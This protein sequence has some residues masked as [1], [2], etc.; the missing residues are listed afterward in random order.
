MI[1]IISKERYD[2][3]ID[4]IKMYEESDKKL[5]DEVIHAK[6]QLKETIDLLSAKIEKEAALI[7]EK[8][9]LKSKITK[10]ENQIKKMQEEEKKH[11][12]IVKD[13]LKEAHEV[14]KKRVAK[15]ENKK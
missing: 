11:K 12:K 2:E 7:K 14:H 3:L 4:C 9:T 8:T 6:T 5:T 10:L 13:T 1:K 15:K